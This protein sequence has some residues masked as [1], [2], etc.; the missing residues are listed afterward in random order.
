MS[1]HECLNLYERIIEE[2]HKNQK[3]THVVLNIPAYNELLT[4]VSLLSGYKNEIKTV[5]KIYDRRILKSR[6]LKQD[7]VLGYE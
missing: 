6:E 3:A 5:N 4:C 7:F 2:I 1:A